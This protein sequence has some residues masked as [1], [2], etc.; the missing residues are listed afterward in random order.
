MR[1]EGGVSSLGIGWEKKV[2]LIEGSAR[3]ELTGGELDSGDWRGVVKSLLKDGGENA[4]FEVS[5]GVSSGALSLVSGMEA[6]LSE[7]VR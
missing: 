3:G 4:F 1:E 5:F 2:E 6:I 7:V